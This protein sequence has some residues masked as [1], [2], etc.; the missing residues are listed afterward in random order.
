MCGQILPLFAYVCDFS[1]LYYSLQTGK[2]GGVV[3]IVPILKDRKHWIRLSLTVD[4][5]GHLDGGLKRNE[6]AVRIF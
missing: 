6:S 3:L 2:R 4:H 1:P 5:F